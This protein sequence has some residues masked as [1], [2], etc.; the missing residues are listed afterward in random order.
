MSIL[1][2][3]TD[4]GCANNQKSEN[5]GGWGAILEYGENV[6]ELCGGELNTTNN[7]MEMTALIEA[8]STLK[9]SEL[10]IEVFSD[11][12]YL[13]NCFREKWYVAWQKNGWLTSAKKPVENRDLWEKLIALTSEHTIKF[14]RVKGHVAIDNPATGAEKLYKKFIDWN[15]DN[16]TYEDFVHI[17]RMNIRADELVHIGM[18]KISE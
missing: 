13:I 2:I 12:S 10:K 5:I 16:F 1:K 6:K 3:H 4:G 17:T 14:N 15:G 7:R 8:L 9:R 18:K 11:S